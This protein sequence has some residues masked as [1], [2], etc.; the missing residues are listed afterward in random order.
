MKQ[1]Y[2]KDNV[3]LYAGAKAVG[4]W[5][6]NLGKAPANFEWVDAGTVDITNKTVWFSDACI[7]GARH[8]KCARKIAWLCEPP[9]FRKS[10]YDY[11]RW[12]EHEFDYILMFDKTLLD[13]GNPK[14]LYYPMGGSFVDRA[15]WHHNPKVK[16]VSLVLSNKLEATGHKLRHIIASEFGDRIDV[17]GSGVG[18]YVRKINTLRD[19][20][21]TICIESE[22]LDWFFNDKLVDAWA[23]YTIPIYWGYKD[24]SKYGFVLPFETHHELDNL[25]S[26]ITMDGYWE[27]NVLVESNFSKA[28]EYY[29]AEDWIWT[30]Y[31]QLF[32]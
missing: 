9:P 23:M 12:Y 11:V 21:F 5:G 1:A 24:V 31:P 8:A 3:F 18:R 15:Q 27:M 10:H 22:K 29:C 19:Y 20:A 16:L 2:I 28:H 4:L 14:Y 7:F 17:M 26:N 6:D 13:S 32:D 30:H 25:L